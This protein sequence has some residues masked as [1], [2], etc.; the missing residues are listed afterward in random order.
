M[1]DRQVLLSTKGERQI[2]DDIILQANNDNGRRCK[3]YSLAGDCSYWVSQKRVKDK[4]FL[5]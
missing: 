4:A 5:K 1:S 3:S 2:S